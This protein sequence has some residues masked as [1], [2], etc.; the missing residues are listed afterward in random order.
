M[1]RRDKEK[2]LETNRTSSYPGK[3]TTVLGSDAELDGTLSFQEGLKVDGIFTGEL[4]TNGLFVVGK[5][6]EVTAEQVKAGT[7]VVEGKIN[8]NVFADGKVEIRSTGQLFGD[9]TA[10]K[11]TIHEGATFVGKCEVNPAK[12]KAGLFP[13]KETVLEK[14]TNGE[15]ATEPEVEENDDAWDDDFALHTE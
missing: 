14:T 15:F 1:L 3:I 7:I 5:K 2:V 11:L 6:G 9:V 8:G 13:G 12:A 10:N 4:K